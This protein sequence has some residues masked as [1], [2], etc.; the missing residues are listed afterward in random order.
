M[1]RSMIAVLLL[2]VA[3]GVASAQTRRE[4]VAWI[5]FFTGGGAISGSGPTLTFL[6]DEATFRVYKG[7]GIGTD[8]A[9][10][11]EP[12]RGKTF[13]LFSGNLSYHFKRSDKVGPFI[14]GGYSTIFRNGTREDGANFGAGIKYWFRDHLG[15]HAELRNHILTGQ[16]RRDLFEVRVGI[17]MR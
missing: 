15:L 17:A 12:D 1:R 3:S 9:S 4:P 5:S 10:G 13:V 6:G 11:W 2:I 14:T 7:L 16:G 8:G